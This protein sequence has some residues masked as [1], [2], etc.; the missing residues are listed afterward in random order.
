MTILFG[1]KN[2]DTVKKARKY[3]DNKA[4]A[5]RFHDFRSDGIS[6][7]LIEQWLEQIPAERL[8]NKRS[9]TW[10]QLEPAEKEQVVQGDIIAICIAQP[11]LLKR[12]ILVHDN[13]IYNGFSEKNYDEIF[14]YY[15]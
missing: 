10:K 13:S 14:K 3:L 8:I 2:C 15:I 6:K 5:Y 7:E 12:P 1:I 9:T 11:T 4:I